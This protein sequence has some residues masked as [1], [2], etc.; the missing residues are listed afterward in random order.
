MVI[1]PSPSRT[2]TCVYD[3]DPYKTRHLIENFLAR[4]K[5]FSAIATRFDKRAVNFLGAIYLAASTTWLDY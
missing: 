4:L 3:E 1:P 2:V 5:Q